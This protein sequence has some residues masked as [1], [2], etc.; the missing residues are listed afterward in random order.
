MIFTKEIKFCGP[1]E[2]LLHIPKI[3]CTFCWHL[4]VNA[5]HIQDEATVETTD[6]QGEQGDDNDENEREEPTATPR[7]S[8]RRET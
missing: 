2:V 8:N 1:I 4:K 5:P 6:N 7:R 3:D